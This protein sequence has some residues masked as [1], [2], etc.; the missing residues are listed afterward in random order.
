MWFYIATKA[1]TDY[2]FHCGLRCLP[3][4]HLYFRIEDKTASDIVFCDVIFAA[5]SLTHGVSGSASVSLFLPA[6]AGLI[7]AVEW[8]S[9]VARQSSARQLMLGF[10]SVIARLSCFY[11]D[12]D[13]L[14]QNIIGNRR[15]AKC[16]GLLI[17]HWVIM[18]VSE[19]HQR[20]SW[21]ARLSGNSPEIAKIETCVAGIFSACS[22]TFL[23]SRLWICA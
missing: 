13:E 12:G 3:T 6:D 4:L 8:W 19:Q 10:I 14:R 15:I 18:S 11:E 5:F 21:H 1:S 7:C 22:M 20:Y 23:V 17:L 16:P 9:C 2:L